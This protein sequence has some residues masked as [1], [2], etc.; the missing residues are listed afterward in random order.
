MTKHSKTS[1][2]SLLLIISFVVNLLTP[3]FASISA[4]LNSDRA[5][6]D[7]KV[8]I[9]TQNG[10]KWINPENFYQDLKTNSDAQADVSPANHEQIEHSHS[11]CPLCGMDDD[12]KLLLTGYSELLIAYIGNAN[13]QTRRAASPL[14]KTNFYLNLPSRAPPVTFS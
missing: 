6:T 14:L 10:V 1:F 12:Q 9:C 2:P 4:N 8:L 11:K 7:K 3:S 13:K 5:D